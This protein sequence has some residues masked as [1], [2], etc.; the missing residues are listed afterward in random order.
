VLTGI[1]YIDIRLSSV[2]YVFGVLCFFP[3]RIAVRISNCIQFKDLLFSCISMPLTPGRLATSS[4]NIIILLCKS[5][6]GSWKVRPYATWG[7]RSFI[8]TTAWSIAIVIMS[9]FLW[10]VLF[11]LP[12]D[13][14]ISFFQVVP[15]R[16]CPRAGRTKLCS[17]KAIAQPNRGHEIPQEINLL[18]LGTVRPLYRTGVLLLSRERFLYI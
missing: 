13:N 3:R 15:H 11:F 16:Y 7:L 5:V 18:P 17:K 10:F 14:H 2:F 6:P 9:C 8:L 1:K 4:Y 12:W